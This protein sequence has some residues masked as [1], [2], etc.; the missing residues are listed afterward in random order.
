MKHDMNQKPWLFCTKPRPHAELRLFC[1]PFS[2]GGAS[3]FR[4]WPETMGNNVEVQPIQLPGRESRF[5]EP[6]VTD[7]DILV[8]NIVDALVPLQ[9]KEFAIFGYS[10]GA[11]IA[12]E[13]CRE[14]RKN[15]LAMPVHL[16]VA[17]M[18]APQSPGV[19]PPLSH[20]PDDIF[21]QQIEHYYQP[22]NDAWN[23]LELR[24]LFL[25][26]LKDDFV[27]ADNYTYKDENPLP[28]P[29][30][31]FAGAEDKGAPPELTRRWSEQ[32]SNI[33]D[34]HLYPGGHFFID[35]ALSDIQKVIKEKLEA[36]IS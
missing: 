7:A 18:R 15:N 24:E 6:R 35:N 1:L 17:A 14:L 2:G 26:V 8:R 12:F 22:Q 36:N 3:F 13:V 10:L 19:H 33:M 28:C 29:I 25:P 9:D 16:F 31:V 21:V 34:Y 27:L 20:L 4:D 11:L 5:H 32:T 30:D 23:T